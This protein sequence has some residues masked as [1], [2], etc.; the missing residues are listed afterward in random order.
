MLAADMSPSTPS[1]AA[2]PAGAATTL[3]RIGFLLVD[4]FS[5]IAFAAACEPLRL[6]NRVAGQDCYDF[7]LFSADGESCRASNGVEVRTEGRFAEAGDRDALI[8]CAGLDVHLPDHRALNAVLRRAAARGAMI[9]A[10]CTGAHVLAKAGLIDGYRATVHWENMPS[11][12]AAHPEVAFGSDL[13]EIDRRRMTCAGGTAAADMMLA[14][15]MREHGAAIASAVADQLIHHRIRDSSERQRMDLRMRLGVANGKL[16]SAVALMGETLAE[17]M[18]TAALAKAVQVS[19]RQ[20]ERLFMKYLG[21]SPSR[22]Y[23]TMRLERARDLIRQTSLPLIDIA[24][25][26]GFTS[27]SHFSKTY[28]GC[29]GNPPSVE[30]RQ[31]RSRLDIGSE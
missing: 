6:A 12:T 1:A 25:D 24:T 17:P 7:S 14:I 4:R 13:Y 22:H 8:V 27:A 19:P 10:V 30:R 3:R 29:F 11:L 18:S 20:L 9:G 31:R 26:C 2:R 16:L 21:Q 15:I 5:M 28:A 23:L